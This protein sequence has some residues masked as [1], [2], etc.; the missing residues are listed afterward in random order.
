MNYLKEENCN[1]TKCKS[2]IFRTDGNQ[3][4]LSNER[5]AEILSY[6]TKF[7]SSHICHVTNKT[8][9]GGLEVTAQALFDK[10]VLPDNKVETLLTISNYYLNKKG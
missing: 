10:G 6:L 1:K 2:C 7:E 9:F 5:M 8:Y 3:V 4:V